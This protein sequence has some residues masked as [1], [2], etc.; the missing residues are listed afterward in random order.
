MMSCLATHIIFRPV[1][2]SFRGLPAHKVISALLKLEP[3]QTGLAFLVTT[4]HEHNDGI[5]GIVDCTLAEAISA[6]M[7]QDANTVRSQPVSVE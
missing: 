4:I 3:A 1:N 6:N 7:N 5:C 2:D